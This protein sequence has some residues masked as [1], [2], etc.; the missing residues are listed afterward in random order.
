[1]NRIGVEFI[2]EIPPCPQAEPMSAWRI[3][4][5]PGTRGSLRTI[6][7]HPAMPVHELFGDEWRVVEFNDL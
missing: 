2:R 6:A 7:A 4:L 3:A 1:M 5:W